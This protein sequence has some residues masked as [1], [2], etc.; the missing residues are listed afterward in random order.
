MNPSCECTNSAY[1]CHIANST[2]LRHFPGER[3]YS[4][5][6]VSWC[7]WS[8]DGG[9]QRFLSN[10]DEL[11]LPTCARNWF[12]YLCTLCVHTWQNQVLPA[13]ERFPST[14]CFQSHS[15][16]SLPYSA[17]TPKATIRLLT[18]IWHAAPMP[19][20]DLVSIDFDDFS[21]V[22]QPRRP[23]GLSPLQRHFHAVQWCQ[24]CTMSK[25]TSPC[26]F[27]IYKNTRPFQS[28]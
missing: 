1:N 11:F 26:D 28:I 5:K 24:V 27:S 18:P 3:S 25:W 9:R 12:A 17:V 16:L 23:P 8:G 15:L 2:R 19:A 20:R 21:L 13:H 14:K 10:K 7:Q 4:L 22:G 6:V